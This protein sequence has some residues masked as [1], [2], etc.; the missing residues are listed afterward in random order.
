M[1]SIDDDEWTR[2]WWKF[3]E[4][5]PGFYVSVCVLL[6]WRKLYDNIKSTLQGYI[7]SRHCKWNKHSQINTHTHTYNK[8]EKLSYSAENS[9]KRTGGTFRWKTTLFDIWINKGTFFSECFIIVCKTD[10]ISQY[11]VGR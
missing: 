8:S 4:A 10:T 6:C 2:E 5:S 9:L 3:V 11:Q 7:W 1:S